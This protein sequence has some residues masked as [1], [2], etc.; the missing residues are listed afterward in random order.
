MLII[1]CKDKEYGYNFG[2]KVYINFRD[3]NKS[4]FIRLTPTDPLINY[5]N[6]RYIIF[7]VYNKKIIFRYFEFEEFN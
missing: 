5:S 2:N 3:N 4:K 6:F 1:R 7:E